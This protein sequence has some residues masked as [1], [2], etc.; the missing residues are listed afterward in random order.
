M[1]PSVD[2]GVCTHRRPALAECLRSLDGLVLPDGLVAGVIVADNDDIASARA[3][4]EAW[5]ATSSHDV[6]YLHAPA[7][8]ISI[9]RNAIL[10]ASRAPR[11]A[12]IDDDETVDPDW[13]AELWRRMDET[14]AAAVLGPVRSSFG[15]A[16]PAWMRSGTFH[17]TQPV[18]VRGSIRTGYTCNVLLDT[19]APAVRGRRF[20]PAL[21]RSGGE[22]TAFLSAVHAAGGSID[23][24]ERALVREHVPDERATMRWLLQR[25]YRF[26]Q[27]HAGQLPPTGA[28]GRIGR[29]AVALA[30]LGA[31]GAQAAI[32][33]PS[34]IGRRR[35]ILRG[36]LHWGAVCSL[37]GR[38]TIE[39]Y[40]P[41]ASSGAIPVAAAARADGT[42]PDDTMLGGTTLDG[43]TLDGTGPDAPL[44]SV[45]IA[46]HDAEAFVDGAIRSALAQ[47]G[48]ALEVIVV[49]DASRDATRAVVEAVGD[50]RVRL[51]G[52]ST[53]VGP[54]GARNA[55]IDAA[56]GRWIAV[57][58]ADDAM[59]PTRLARLSAQGDAAR[60]DV[61]A[62]DLTIEREG[63]PPLAMFGEDRLARL[64]PLR[65]DALLDG[66]RVF[67]GRRD[68]GYLKPLLRREFLGRHRLRY[69]AGLRVGEDF[70]LLARAL[71]AGASFVLEPR[72][73]YRYRVRAGSISHRLDAPRLTAMMAADERLAHAH[74]LDAPS[75]RALRRRRR[76]FRDALTFTSAVEALKTGRPA[77]AL[78]AVAVRP[79]ALPLFRMPIGARLSRALSH[80]Q[81]PQSAG[82]VRP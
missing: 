75:L 73:G 81:A 80:V 30:K 77:A 34:P 5:K 14:G 16:A 7:H 66:S 25:R 10:H 54:G 76:A 33:L 78:R 42:K 63:R 57:L 12:F 46:A 43:T 20:D 74:A 65:L 71:A 3:M 19:G 62:D 72:A 67:G 1:N 50:P 60:A 38:R 44:V 8:N 58:D 45:V 13:L 40:A 4:V 31:C 29:V 21:G 9:A 69:D 28:A 47:R 68:L 27:T 55:A 22:D 59:E 18:R 17:D 56:R 6:T 39:P 35:A 70:D 53:N 36:A 32:A 49:D 51:V 82:A 48:V 24:A 23:Y 37:L 2:I 26:G 52:L 79:S 41:P 64:S 15:A 11:L 61:V